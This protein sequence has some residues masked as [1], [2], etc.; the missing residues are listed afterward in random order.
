MNRADRRRRAKDD[1]KLL[2]FGIDPEQQSADQTAAMARQLAVLLDRAK[3]EKSIDAPVQYLHSRIDATLQRFKG[4]AVACKKG[5]AHCCHIWVSV[6]IPE[7]LFVAKALR[8]RGNTTAAEKIRAVHHATTAFDFV[9]RGTHPHP[10]P[11]LEDSL[12]SVYVVRPRACRFAASFDA[13]VCARSY[14]RGANE[15]IPMPMGSVVAR[16]A[17]A[18]ALAIALKHEQ[19]PYH[20]YEFNGALARALERDDAERA[21]LAGEDVFA[22]VMRDPSDVFTDSPAYKI[23]SYAFADE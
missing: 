20:L 13:E 22:D 6:T 12:C 11:L 5:C 15:D 21:W 14:L 2:H 18:I 23:Y 8:R 4:I 19:L 17:Y 3:R 7:V 16:N 10:C 9:A 1:E